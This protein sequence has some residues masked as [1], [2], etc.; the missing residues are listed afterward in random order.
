MFVVGAAIAETDFAGK[1]RFGE[2]SQSAIDG[3]LADGWIFFADQ[4]VKVLAG[5][6]AFSLQKNVQNQVSLGSSLQTLLLDV[7]EENFLLFSHGRQIGRRAHLDGC[8]LTLPE[9]CQK[10]RG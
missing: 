8:I 6:V 9:M 5:E 7:L 10:P 3:G 1:A 4:I 2:Q